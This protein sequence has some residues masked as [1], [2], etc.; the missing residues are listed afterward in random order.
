MATA[1][2]QIQKNKDDIALIYQQGLQGQIS[3]EAE[4]NELQA[5]EIAVQSQ[6]IQKLEEQDEQG[7]KDILDLQAKN[8]SQDDQINELERQM[9]QGYKQIVPYDTPFPSPLA[10]NDGKM[11]TTPNPLG[12][13]P[14]T[15]TGIKGEWICNQRELFTG[16]TNIIEYPLSIPYQISDNDG[17]IRN[18]T[19]ICACWGSGSTVNSMETIF[20][21][22]GPYSQSTI[23][24]IRTSNSRISVSF[25]GGSNDFSVTKN[26]ENKETVSLTFD[27]E[28]NCDFYINGIY[29]G[30]PVAGESDAVPNIFYVFGADL[31]RRNIA[32]RGQMLRI[33]EY[34]LSADEILQNDNGGKPWLYQIDSLLYKG[35]GLLQSNLTP[36]NN[37]EYNGTDADGYN[38]ICR[39][40]NGSGSW[41]FITGDSYEQGAIIVVEGKVY[42][43]LDYKLPT[44]GDFRVSN[45]TIIRDF[46][47][48]EI[49]D[50]TFHFTVRLR[51]SNPDSTSKIYM[52]M[53]WEDYGCKFLPSEITFKQLGISHE[54]LPQNLQVN[55]WPDSASN[56]PLKLIKAD[57]RILATV[58]SE[59]SYPKYQIGVKAPDST[60]NKSA[61]DQIFDDV[62]SGKSYKPVT[63]ST[64]LVWKPIT[65]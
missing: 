54:L 41:T 43:Y 7:D 51:I 64:G 12:G 27:N 5:Q 53:Q 42:Q 17:I 63:T 32:A 15:Y 61:I 13:A 48:G 62:V 60:A 23:R 59:Q 28:G 22:D 39:D 2:E 8:R 33:F 56:S 45:A 34:K 47:K 35:A 55:Q 57:G 49:I 40:A 14:L 10:G 44:I 50:N 3:Q 19:I 38:W 46:V 52:C 1:E 24:C 37:G 4:V 16:I 6:R 30:S 26:L 11:A 58:T 31:Y 21:G 36:S 20:F 18:K 65:T 29:I 9:Q 25:K